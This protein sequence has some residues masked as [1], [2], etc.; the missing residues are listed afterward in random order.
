MLVTI[1]ELDFKATKRSFSLPIGALAV[2]TKTSA[3]LQ[4]V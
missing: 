4:S 2:I 1:L 3:S